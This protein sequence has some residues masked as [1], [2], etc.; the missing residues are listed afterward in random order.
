MRR[1]SYEKSGLMNSWASR[2]A[3]PI[4]VHSGTLPQQAT[5]LAFLLLRQDISQFL[6]VKCTIS[7]RAQHHR[8]MERLFNLLE[9]YKEF[10]KLYQMCKAVDVMYSKACRFQHAIENTR[11]VLPA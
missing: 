7:E 10:F 9:H 2:A 11:P 6:S 5:C 4:R 3:G 8:R 1:H